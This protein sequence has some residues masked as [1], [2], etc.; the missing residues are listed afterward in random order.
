MSLHTIRQVSIAFKF[1]IAPVE[2]TS[3]GPNQLIPPH[4][5]QWGAVSDPVVVVDAAVVVVLV[6]VGV[7]EDYEAGQICKVILGRFSYYRKTKPL[8]VLLGEYINRMGDATTKECLLILLLGPL[9][10][11]GLDR[12]S[13]AVYPQTRTW[14]M[15]SVE[16]RPRWRSGWSSSPSRP[17]IA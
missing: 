9:S 14:C 15:G 6:A 8:E 17:S 1:R 7:T 10:P 2:D 11:P 16:H 5:P 12:I 3:V 13:P 4:W